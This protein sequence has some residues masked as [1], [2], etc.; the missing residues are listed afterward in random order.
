MDRDLIGYGANPTQPQL[1]QPGSAGG[2]LRAELRGRLRTIGPRWR[3]RSRS[4]ALTEYGGSKSRRGWAGPGGRGH[5]RLRQPSQ[6]SGAILRLFQE[7]GLPMT[8]FG[9]RA[10]AG[11]KPAGGSGNQAA[12]GYDIC[13]HGWRWEKHFEL[14]E[15][16]E[17][18]RIARAV[19]SL[20]SQHGCERP[21][22]WYC[23]SGPRRKHPAA[24]GRGR[25]LSLRFGCLRRRTPILDEGWWQ[26]ASGRAIQPVHQRLEVRPRHVR[27]PATTSSIIAGTRSTSFTPRAGRSR[28]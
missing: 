20:A 6:V 2:Q 16:V 12:A 18:Q 3:S 21:L 23:R 7:R 19:A 5:V 26:A 25:R 28:R 8:I 17:R 22:G 9:L 14:A 27:A 15:D 1:A 11:T 4:G 24:A 13:C 10:R